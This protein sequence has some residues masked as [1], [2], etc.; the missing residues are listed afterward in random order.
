MVV[1]SV[2]GAGLI[3][4]EGTA[5]VSQAESNSSSNA[6]H[7]AEAGYRYALSHI[8]TIEDLH[9]ETFILDSGNSFT[10]S[11][12]SY[13]FEITG[14]SGTQIQ[15]QIPFGSVP[16]SDIS[17]SGKIAVEN[18]IHDYS[19]I[20]VIGDVVNFTISSGGTLPSTGKVKLSALKNGTSTI[21]ENSTISLKDTN[22]LNLFPEYNGSFTIGSEQFRYLSRTENTL[23]GI[24]AA[25]GTWPGDFTLNDDDAVNLDNF[26]EVHSTGNYGNAL[27]GTKRLLAY[28][29]SS[30]EGTGEEEPI[31]HFE[32][33]DDWSPNTGTGSTGEGTFDTGDI[34]GDSALI[35][36]GVTN[37]IGSLDTSSIDYDWQDTDLDLND[38]W[39]TAGNLLSY[40]VQVKIMVDDPDPSTYAPEY[41]GMADN[42]FYLA[43]IDDPRGSWY[44]N[45]DF[46]FVRDTL[47][48][49]PKEGFKVLL[50]HRPGDRKNTLF[51]GGGF[52]FFGFC[53]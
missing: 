6:F 2:L 20:E 3:S 27:L 48:D 41:Q 52:D 51:R 8:D 40:N 47:K 18:V 32:D 13:D 14:T 35:I 4:I 26:V 37:V 19:T 33:K 34:D 5:V 31:D 30:E 53:P 49:V 42:Y 24:I 36:T 50:S 45:E 7:L 21:T 1:V 17:E 22:P 12:E 25:D 44:L 38:I 15:T 46:P 10:I 23:I 43:G 28:N 11:L 9:D 16:F 39:D 29:F